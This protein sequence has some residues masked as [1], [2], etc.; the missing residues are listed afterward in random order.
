MI[1]TETKAIVIHTTASNTRNTIGQIMHYFLNVLR[2]N[3]GGYHIIYDQLGNKQELYSWRTEAT[4]GILPS[5][6]GDLHNANTIHLSYIG[7]INNLNQNEA[8]CNITPT[9]EAQIIEDIKR[10]LTW[11]PKAKIIGHNQINQKACPS[12]WVPDWGKKWGIG[13]DNIDVRDPYNIKEWV[14]NSIPHPPN[15]YASKVEAKKVCPT[16]KQEIL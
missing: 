3:K 15:F 16:C 12:F 2:W 6:T 5:P 4:N 13:N 8:V 10:I 7:G 14:K 1:R 9:Q 11:F